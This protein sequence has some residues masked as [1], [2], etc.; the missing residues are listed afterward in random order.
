MYKKNVMNTKK[1]RIFFL[2]MICSLFFTL[3][4]FAV[5]TKV[6]KAA[7][8]SYVTD[9][10]KG[11]VIIF[12]GDSRTM[13]MTAGYMKAMR[14]NCAFA[15]VNGGGVSCIDSNGKLE[16]HL[17][18]LIKKYRDRCVVI[19]NFGI[20]GNGNYKKNSANL[21]R[22]YRKY[23]AEYPDVKFF[24]ES[25]NPSGHNKG[26]V[27]NPK[28]DKL[29]A[30]LKEEFKDQYIDVSTYLLENGIVTKTGKG[31]KYKLHYKRKANRMIISYL[32]S[33]VDNY[34]NSL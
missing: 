22:I 15:W 3:D 4:A 21:I 18:R 9:D 12:A 23:M 31:T 7:S 24:V 30:I 2:M 26:G 19:F 5:H 29:N 32:K 33:F 17:H 1:W 27:G 28:I 10:Y 20:N 16:S 11:K 13:Y 6:G 25:V 34:Y 8:R 14:T